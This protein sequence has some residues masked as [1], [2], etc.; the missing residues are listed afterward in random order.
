M[1]TNQVAMA[2]L[3]GAVGMC[4]ATGPAQAASSDSPIEHGRYVVMISGCNDCHT[5]GFAQSGGKVPESEWLK[6]DRLGWRGP[7]GTTFAPNLRLYLQKLSEDDWVKAARALK[8][9]PPMP[10]WALHAM[11]EPDLRALYRFVRSLGEPGPQA[12]AYL[13]PTK[14]P[15][16][17]YIELVLPP[18][19]P[20]K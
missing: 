12:P 2:L 13:P 14:A 19:K 7:W 1:G 20:T 11:S 10:W 9:R 5:A 8:T 17:P 15:A 3:W 18:A 4:S 16:P 6:G